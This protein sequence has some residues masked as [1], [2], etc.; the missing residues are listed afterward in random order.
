M[1][2]TLL[3]FL[4]V[5]GV[6]VF[7]HELGH[8]LVAR[9]HGVR[10]LT[11]S[12]GFGPKLFSI[13]RGDTEYCISIIPLG[14]YV[15]MAGEASDY[16]TEATVREGKPD[17]FLSKTKWQRFQI[18]LAGPVMNILL[19]LVIMT[20]VI[21]A[22][23]TEFIYLK[24]P[25]VIGAVLPKSAAD[26]AGIKPGDQI[27]SVAD[28][29]VD[30]WDRLDLL[31]MPRAGQELPVVVR[32]NGQDMTLRITPD[33]RTTW[34][35]GDLGVA[36]VLHPQITV[37]NA[38][39]PAEHA[40]LQVG[41]VI[42]AVDGVPVA[43]AAMQDA[44]H[45]SAD[46]PLKLTIERS[47]Q[48]KDVMVTPAKKGDV[49]LI[50]VTFSIGETRRIEPTLAQAAKMSAV[51]N[52]EWSTLIF[53]TFGGLFSGQTSI[54]QLSGPVGIAR[55]SGGAARAGW[56]PLFTLMC[57]ISLNLGIL[58]LLPIPMLD[59]GHIFIM[60]LEGVARRDFSMRVKEKMLMAGFLVIMALMVT[61]IYNDLMRIE[62]IERLVPWR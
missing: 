55:L 3:P 9:W 56:I 27:V 43:Y 57:M 59:G 11:F 14:G 10:V 31:V 8:F 42:I 28:K 16:I 50:G 5:L 48:R 37:V 25:A 22:G 7:V 40:G 41:D 47:G 44:I 6:L 30:T 39:E 52:L 2:S 12:L 35:M 1:I 13:K 29:P 49:G 17:E 19:A 61:V 15:K 62:W 60:T 58:N 53:Q 21:Y 46:K 38:D 45:A 54:K 4:F 18:F 23:A 34:Q 51:Q 36:P 32:R 20:F 24:K 33:T 26:H